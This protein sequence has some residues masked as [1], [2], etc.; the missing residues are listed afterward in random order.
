MKFAAIDIG[1]NAVRLLLSRAVHRDPR[2][3]FKKEALVR[4]PLRLGEDAFV[5][6]R[7]TAEKADR[8]VETMIGFRHLM[9]AYDPISYRACAT[10][11]MR[12][13]E[14]GPD[15]VNRVRAESGIQLEIISGQDEANVIYANHFEE[16][17]DREC[18]YLYID[19]G[20]GS[21][22]ITVFSR[23][24]SLTSRSFQ[25][26]TVRSLMGLVPESAWEDMKRWVKAVAPAFGPLVGI[27]SGGNINKLSKM[28]RLKDGRPVKYKKLAELRDYLD[29]FSVE[30][31]VKIL[32]LRP[33]RAD[34]IVPAADIFLSVLRWAGIKRL[35]VPEIGIADG[36]IRMLYDA[37]VEAGHAPVAQT[38]LGG[39]TSDP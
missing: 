25:I 1:S 20:G 19:V 3:L 29:T 17:L 9:R 14:N 11:A 8:L 27:G 37:H 15:L 16:R 39:V 22:E 31:R 28:L 10:S 4:M 35:F 23:G 7:I 18:S 2:P 32:A 13:S 24:T 34:V 38:E 33:D 12:E 21:T 36:L 30:E 26:G 5:L 6:H